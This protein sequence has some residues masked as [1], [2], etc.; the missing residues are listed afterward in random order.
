MKAKRKS[1]RAKSAGGQDGGQDDG[2]DGLA[3]K[4]RKRR[5][6]NNTIRHD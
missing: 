6:K 5:I 1:A 2:Q 3:A 4:R